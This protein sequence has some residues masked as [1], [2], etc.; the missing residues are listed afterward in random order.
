[1][2]SGCEGIVIHT[3]L[4]SRKAALTEDDKKKLETQTKDLEK[5]YNEKIAG[6]FRVFFLH[7]CLNQ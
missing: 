2:P 4:F 3:Q 7:L 1:M 5:D 6:Q